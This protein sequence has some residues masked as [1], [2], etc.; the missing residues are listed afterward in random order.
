MIPSTDPCDI[1]SPTLTRTDSIVPATSAGTSIDALSVSSV[2]SGSSIATL[3]PAA[4]CISIT[5]TTSKSPKSGTTSDCLPPDFFGASPSGVTMV[6]LDINGGTTAGAINAVSPTSIVIVPITSPVEIVSPTA[7]V[8]VSITPFSG[9]GM[10][11]DALSVSTMI[12]PSSRSTVSPAATSTSI[13]SMFSKSPRSGITMSII[14]IISASPN[15]Y[16]VTG[17]GRSGLMPYF[18]IACATVS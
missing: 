1:L 15:R 16:S 4:M 13:T 6:S 18:W 7:T 11:S 8:N 3:S 5:S 14:F 17:S 9:E 12:K 10:S 2:T